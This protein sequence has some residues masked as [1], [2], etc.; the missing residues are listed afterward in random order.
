[1]PLLGEGRPQS[2][3]MSWWECARG[4]AVVGSCGMRSWWDPAGCGHG[5]ILRDVAVVGALPHQKTAALALHVWRFPSFSCS[6]DLRAHVCVMHTHTH[7]CWC[8]H[9]LPV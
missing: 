5:G 8:E 7:V 3:A 4:A 9:R 2:Q 6:H 1:M